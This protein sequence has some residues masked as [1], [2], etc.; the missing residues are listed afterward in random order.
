MNTKGV[1]CASFFGGARNLLLKG[2]RNLLLKGAAQPTF[3]GRCAT[4]F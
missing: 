1:G 4:H 2:A 3:E